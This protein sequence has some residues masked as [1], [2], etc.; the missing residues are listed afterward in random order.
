MKWQTRVAVAGALLAAGVSTPLRA[1]TTVDRDV[2]AYVEQLRGRKSPATFDAGHYRCGDIRI[3]VPSAWTYGGTLP[4]E[5]ADDDT[6]RWTDPATKITVNAW[7]SKRKASPDGVTALLASAIANKTAQREREGWRRWTV[8]PDSVQEATVGG[9]RALRAVADF[10]PRR[11]GGMRVE[12][13]T[14]IFTPESRVLAFATMSAEQ[15]TAFQP[16][17]D[18]VVQS[19]NE[20]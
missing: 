12:Y 8:R 20:P 2:N 4:G 11:G 18:R 17:F 5:T 3:D 19:I 13:L 6:A 14:W 9:H 10:E 16:D 7:V 1:Q 15:L